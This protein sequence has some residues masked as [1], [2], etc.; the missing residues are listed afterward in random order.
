MSFVVDLCV[1]FRSVLRPFFL[2]FFRSFVRWLVRCLFVVALFCVSRFQYLARPLGVPSTPLDGHRHMSMNHP[3]F[4]LSYGTRVESYRKL[5]EHITDGG[6]M[7]I[8]KL[9]VAFLEE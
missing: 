8:P 7:W 6:I 5:F 9:S 3:K 1:F 4:R 2:S